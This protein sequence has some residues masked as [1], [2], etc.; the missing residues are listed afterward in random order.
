MNPWR[1]LDI[2]KEI[3]W[4][5]THHEYAK[6]Y[7]VK[8]AGSFGVHLIEFPIFLPSIGIKSCSEKAAS[9]L[10]AMLSLHIA[11]RQMILVCR[12]GTLGGGHSIGHTLG[13]WP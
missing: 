6:M 3:F 7:V 9:G 2:F 4:P 11:G 8:I 1:D 13:K 5:K 10:V 12:A